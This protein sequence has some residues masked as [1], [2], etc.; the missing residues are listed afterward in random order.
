MAMRAQ[1]SLI[2][3]DEDLYANFILPM[4]E[5]REL[6]NIIIKCL[7]AYYYNEEVR[8][9]IQSYDLEEQD[10]EDNIIEN[11][12]QSVVDNIRSTLALQSF[13]VTE[14]ENTIQ[15]GTDTF[16]DILNKS[17][18]IMEE[19]AFVKPAKKDDFSAGVPLLT[20]KTPKEVEEIKEDLSSNKSDGDTIPYNELVSMVMELYK[21]IGKQ[22][23]V[24]HE[25]KEELITQSTQ[26]VI[27]EPVVENE[28]VSETVVELENKQNEEDAT[29]AMNDLLSS[30]GF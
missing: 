23:P 20:L 2:F 19:Q 11:T 3:S 24:N 13:C 29:S 5:Q 8:N 12:T 16:S 22:V 6:N 28:V 17:S 7:E 15:D 1:C 14:L 10:D 9:S 4:K 25:Q 27:P 30:L 18:D 26:E 21:S